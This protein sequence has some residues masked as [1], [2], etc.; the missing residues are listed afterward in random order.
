MR[1]HILCQSGVNSKVRVHRQL[2]WVLL[3]WAKFV[4]GPSN[5]LGWDLI[6]TVTLNFQDTWVTRDRDSCAGEWSYSEHAIF[7]LLILS[8][9]GHGS[10]KL[11]IKQKLPRKGLFIT[12]WAGGLMLGRG[13]ISHY[14]E[15]MHYLLLYQYTSFWLLLAADIQIWALLTRSRCRVPDTQVTVKALGPLVSGDL[16]FLVP[17]CWG[18]DSLAKLVNV[19]HVSIFVLFCFSTGKHIIDNGIWHN[20]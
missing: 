13:Y 18:N 16:N 8:T 2:S 7:L 9:L 14:N 5:S 20:T 3:L 17:K 10:D 11:S 12:I 4:E 1:G 6:I 15:Y 19:S